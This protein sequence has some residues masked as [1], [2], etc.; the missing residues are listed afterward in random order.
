MSLN[1]MPGETMCNRRSWRTRDHAQDKQ[2]SMMVIL[3]DHTSYSGHACLIKWTG[4]CHQPR[5]VH[6]LLYTKP[7]KLDGKWLPP[8]RHSKFLLCSVLGPCSV[9]GPPTLIDWK[10]LGEAERKM[11]FISGS[12]TF[13]EEWWTMLIE[14]G[15]EWTLNQSYEFKVLNS[16]STPRPKTKVEHCW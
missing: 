10:L 13:D 4:H 6:W 15:T 3:V 1:C 16:L 14:S 9:V 12:Q 5:H 11:E 7:V 2:T 8:V